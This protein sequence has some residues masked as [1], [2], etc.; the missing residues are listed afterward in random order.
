ML[1]RKFGAVRVAQVARHLPDG[2]ADVAVF[3]GDV[4]DGGWRFGDA[5]FAREWLRFR[6]IF[7]FPPGPAPALHFDDSDR[8]GM[9]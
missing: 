8:A 9:D 2:G 7:W 4:L 3:L 1:P 6:R 5:E